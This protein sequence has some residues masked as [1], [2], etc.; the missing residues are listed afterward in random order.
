MPELSLRVVVAFVVAPLVPVILFV[1][2]NFSFIVITFFYPWA[3]ALVI[4]LGAPAYII[5]ARKSTPSLRLTLLICAIIGIVL[6]ALQQRYIYNGYPSEFYLAGDPPSS[7]AQFQA[8]VGI[9]RQ[10]LTTIGLSVATGLAW[11]AIALAPSNNPLDRSRP[12]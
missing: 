9:S 3:I 5:A 8:L 1:L 7:L 2:P 12:R 6:A 11:W 4:I 10:V